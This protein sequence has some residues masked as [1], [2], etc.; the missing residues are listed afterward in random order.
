MFSAFD[1]SAILEASQENT[2]RTGISTADQRQ[3]TQSSKVEESDSTSAS[4][5]VKPFSHYEALLS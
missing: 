5:T 2:A 4:D 1:S 3:L